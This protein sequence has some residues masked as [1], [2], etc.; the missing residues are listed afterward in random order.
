MHTTVQTWYDIQYLTMCLSGYMDTPIEQAFLDLRHDMEYI[1]HHEHEHIIHS[2][3]KILKI[4]D[5]PL[6]CFLKAVNI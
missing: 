6:K 4:N 5:I 1:M 2:R 3:E